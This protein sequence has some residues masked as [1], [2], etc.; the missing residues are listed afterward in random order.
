M[1]HTL[2]LTSIIFAAI[3]TLNGCSKDE[4]KVNDANAVTPVKED[5]SPPLGEWVL[6]GSTTRLAFTK[7]EVKH[8]E[9]VISWNNFDCKWLDKPPLKDDKIE[10][11]VY[12]HDG[13][14]SK[15]KLKSQFNEYYFKNIKLIVK[16]EDL[17]E[18]D[19]SKR[20]IDY[21]DLYKNDLKIIDTIKEGNY[22]II[23]SLNDPHAGGDSYTNYI[24]DHNN[25]YA[26]IY[27]YDVSGNDGPGHY[28]IQ[29]YSKGV[30][31]LKK[32]QSDKK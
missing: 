9:E 24:Y 14:I 1:K 23:K 4:K 13:T 22:K 18:D 5:V 6:D 2:S 17:S 26:I 10:E 31:L 8:T 7:D 25:L 32:Y 11:C 3:V 15:E 28:M 16:R 12:F 27:I 19:V 29:S 21:T 20:L 30:E